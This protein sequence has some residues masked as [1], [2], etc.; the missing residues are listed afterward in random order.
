MFNRWAGVS[1]IGYEVST[2]SVW[3][4]TVTTVNSAMDTINVSSIV[5]L[6]QGLYGFPRGHQLTDGVVHMRQAMRMPRNV[7]MRLLWRV[8][9]LSN[10]LY[11]RSHHVIS[12]RGRSVHPGAIGR[13]SNLCSTLQEL[14]PKPSMALNYV[15]VAATGEYTSL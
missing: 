5:P 10:F 2:R 11:I 7:Y 12:R 6:C 1:P 8:T 3:I 13:V 15:L 4:R 14:T 9:L